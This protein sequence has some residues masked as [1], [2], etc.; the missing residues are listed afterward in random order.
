MWGDGEIGRGEVICRICKRDKSPGY[1]YKRLERDLYSQ[2]KVCSRAYQRKRRTELP[3]YAR[4][5]HLKRYGLTVQ[6]YREMLAKQNHQCAMCLSEESQTLSVDHHHVSGKVRELLCR[7]C[8]A[9]L[10]L[11]R[12][13]KAILQAAIDYLRKHSVDI[14]EKV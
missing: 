9:L 7:S 5:R 13:N 8:N 2:C 4:T 6:D 14:L 1:F 3:D 12:E 10:G 11:A